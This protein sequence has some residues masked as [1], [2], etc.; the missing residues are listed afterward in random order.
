MSE[1][2]SAVKEKKER[3]KEREAVIIMVRLFIS[4]IIS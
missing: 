2:I 3:K 1:F 4:R